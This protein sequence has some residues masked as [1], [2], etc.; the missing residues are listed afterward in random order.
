MTTMYMVIV[1]SKNKWNHMSK[2]S[3]PV[4]YGKENQ[5]VIEAIIVQD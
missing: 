1:R 4:S 5:S 3:V 2:K